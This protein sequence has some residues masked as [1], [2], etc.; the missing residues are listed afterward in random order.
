[1][2]KIITLLVLVT[3][4]V[5]CKDYKQREQK[6]FKETLKVNDSIK[7]AEKQWIN[8][9][10]GDSIKQLLLKDIPF[11]GVNLSNVVFENEAIC[12]NTTSNTKSF[13]K[14]AI[15]R[16]SESNWRF[17]KKGDY[18]EV[19]SQ[20]NIV[21][22]FNDKKEAENFIATRIWRNQL[23]A[24]SAKVLLNKNKYKISELNFYE[25]KNW[26]RNVGFLKESYEY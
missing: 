23:E 12:C 2:K 15:I 13:I 5:G 17:K 6:G 10:E 19:I 9:K 25:F 3:V 26:L 24:N 4:L 8:S 11:D 22:E 1:M 14:Y 16:G 7:L 18:F 20:N 21:K